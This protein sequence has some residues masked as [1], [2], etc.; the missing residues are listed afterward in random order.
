M[1]RAQIAKHGLFPHD[2]APMAGQLKVYEVPIAYRPKAVLY[3]ALTAS[4]FYFAFIATILVMHVSQLVLL[5][6]CWSPLYWD[7]IRFSQESF[8]RLLVWISGG[9]P[10][11][12][13]LGPGV[14]AATFVKRDG[15]GK[16]VGIDFGSERFGTSP[17]RRQDG[18]D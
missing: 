3:H 1:M 17:R 16:V 9:T 7:Y 18:L 12:L 10:L 15:E 14:D 13:T 11:V 2:L 6:L 4:V 8:A 5:P